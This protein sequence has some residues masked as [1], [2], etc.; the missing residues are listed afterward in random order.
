M[1]TGKSAPNRSAPAAV[2]MAAL[3]NSNAPPTRLPCEGVMAMEI[4]RGHFVTFAWTA[5]ALPG[6]S[7]AW[8]S[9]RGK[10][11]WWSIIDRRERKSRSTPCS[12]SW[13]ERAGADNRLRHLCFHNR[14]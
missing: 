9:S 10:G 14:E 3:A 5:F 6:L 13:Q 7:M 12:R 1:L 2:T 4:T 11:T 8:P